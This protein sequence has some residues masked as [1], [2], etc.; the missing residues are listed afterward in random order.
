M[1]DWLAKVFDVLLALLPGGLWCVW[2]LWGVNWKN[3]W[4]VLARGAWVPV[5]LLM[6]MAA[7]VWSRLAPS[8]CTCLRLVTIPNFWWQLGSVSALVAVSLLCGWLQGK[9]GWAPEEVSFEPPPPAPE[10]GHH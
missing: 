6:F 1:P 5:I 10:H 7:L 2:W 8:P 4:P 9:L 3:A